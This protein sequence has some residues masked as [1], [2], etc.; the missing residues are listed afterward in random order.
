VTTDQA[1]P[2]ALCPSRERLVRIAAMIRDAELSTP[3]PRAQKRRTRD[4]GLIALPVRRRVA[5]RLHDDD[6]PLAS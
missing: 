2:A 3:A 5:R 4:V 6:V 1:S